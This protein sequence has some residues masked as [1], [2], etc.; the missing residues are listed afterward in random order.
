[1]KQLAHVGF[2]RDAAPAG[3]YAV[4]VMKKPDCDAHLRNPDE[5]VALSR[6]KQL[7]GRWNEAREII[8]AAI[9]TFPRHVGVLVE[10]ARHAVRSG[11]RPRAHMW[12]SRAW[13]VGLPGQSWVVEWIEVMTQ[14]GH[15][16]LALHVASAHCQRG[17]GHADGWFWLGYVLQVKGRMHD[18]LEA[19]CKCARVLP[20]RPMLRN[21]MA[22]A[23]LE[24]EEFALAQDLLE[25]E[26]AENPANAA[27]WT[28]L[29]ATLLKRR[30]PGLAL[31]AAERALA[32]APDYPAALQT[33]SYVLKEL[34]R[35]RDAM[36]SIERAY[37][38]K[39]D[40]AS[41]RWSLAMLQLAGGDFGN[42]WANHE[43]RWEG[44]KELR[45]C[46]PSL[47]VPLWNGGSLAGKT[48][49]VWGEQGYGDVLQFVR[50]VPLLVARARRE[51]GKVIYSTFDPLRDL[52]ARS[53]AG[54]VDAVLPST[55]S[56]AS[57]ADCH[58]PLASLPGLFGIGIE[59]LAGCGFP[60][61]KPDLREVARWKAHR[62]AGRELQVGLVW[63]GSR[64]HQRNPMREV[65]PLACAKAF[66]DMGG[67]RFFSLQKD[68]EE[69]VRRM[70]AA[71]LVIED[72]TNRLATFDATA[73]YAAGLD[74]VITVCTA[75]AHLAGG[76]GKPTWLLLDMNPHWVWMSGRDDS[77]W[78]PSMQLYR[79]RKYG[80]WQ[81]ALDSV[82]RDLTLLLKHGAGP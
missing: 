64:N 2:E 66:A 5:L 74:L 77:P 23:Y 8:D 38:L 50:F 51:G 32:L 29:A 79:Q 49:F 54:Y 65:S 76:L 20:R 57:T 46:A 43:S 4:A 80:E 59:D 81:P 10:G 47:P 7:G 18:A 34:G 14:L 35:T 19:Y 30:E 61:L 36:V 48:V 3:S 82:R 52:L 33:H 63:T 73:A 68:A 9:E 13:D 45:N 70:R 28:N 22:A 37:A 75:V 21:N 11:D 55:L 26:L 42:G 67:V 16:D 31:A 41:I 39:R 12:F 72:D 44:A 69:D 15:T 62:E 53:L 78:Y 40:D 27:A 56:L 60:Y 25:D 6:V 1:M 58:V 17:P 24:L 71:G